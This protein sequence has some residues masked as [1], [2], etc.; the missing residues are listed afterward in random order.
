MISFSTLRRKLGDLGHVII[1]A[2]TTMPMPHTRAFVRRYSTKRT[3]IALLIIVIFLGFGIGKSV[4]NSGADS[5]TVV[6]PRQVTTS[7]AGLVSQLE[8]VLETTGEVQSQTQGDLRAQRAGVITSVN[9]RVGQQVRAG[10][11]I[12]SIENASERASVAQAQATVAQATASFNKISG[13]TRDEQLAVLKANTASALQSMNETTASARNTLLSAY[14]A[15]DTAFSGGIDVFFSNPDGA[16]PKLMFVSTNSS[17]AIAAEHGRFILENTINRHAAASE[18]VSTLSNAEVRTEIDVLEK[19]MLEIKSMLDNVISALDGA[20]PTASITTTTIASYKTTA[21]AART[22]IL[23]TLSSLSAARGAL[24]AAQ[25]ALTVAQENE[26]Q[27]ITGAQPEDVAVAQAQLESAQA[28]LAQAVAQLENTRVR[29]PVTGIVTILT[30]DKGDFVTSFQDIGLVANDNALEIET[31]VAPNTIDRIAVGGRA[32][33]NRKH[34]GV[35]TSIAPGVDPVK[36]QVEVRIALVAESVPLTH[37]SRVSVEFLNLASQDI[38]KDD[39]SIRVP[40]SSLKLVGDDAFVFVVNEENILES[41]P[42]KLG[43]VVQSSIE[44]VSGINRN[45]EIV[46]DARGLTEGTTVIVSN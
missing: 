37:G 33:I 21:S 12:A 41:M 38:S 8:S 43:S 29:A 15:S 24:N 34:E 32:L 17:Q 28:T 44:I 18:D 42:V 35:I 16:N 19:E 22:S 13:G 2:Y 36:R 27:G 9:A 30:I 20:V 25:T 6:I 1:S 5:E 11:I 39:A 40:I 7:P 14:A 26:S 46:L 23:G 45:T 31:F 10:T 3:G 4:V